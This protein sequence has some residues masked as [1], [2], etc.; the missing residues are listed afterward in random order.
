MFKRSAF[1]FLF[2]I[3]VVSSF[4]QEELV[5][6]TIG[7]KFHDKYRYSNMLAI[8]DD[9]SD[10]TVVVRAYYTGIILRPKGYF[11]EHYNKDL[12][13]VSEYNYKLKDANFIDA[14]V[15][16]GQVYL[17]FLEYSYRNKSYQYEVHRS[18]F[19]QFQFTK[20]TI[21]SI[22]SD[23]VEQPLDRNFYN[24]NFSSGFTTSIL[25]NDDKSAF[26]ITTHY[27][28]RKV[29]QHT[30]HVFNA[31]LNKLMEHDFSDEVEEKNYA[32]ENIAF[33]K[34]LQNVYLVGKAYF[35]KKRFNATE[36]KFQY[37]MV[38][39]SNSSRS[40]QSFYTPG[41]FPE[42]LKPIFRDNEL[43]CIGF[44]ADRKD[45]RYNGI[46]YFNLDPKTLEMKTEKFNPFSEQFM[47]D[48]FGRE[49]DK[50][51]KDL[52]FK[53]MDITKEGNILF[54]AEEYFTSNSVQ[55]NSSGGR[56]MVTRYHHNDIISAKL[57]ATG[58]VV[59]A[60]NINKTEVTQG[61]GAYASYSSYTKN[62][63]TYFFISTSSENPQQL[64]DD[65]I[66]FKQGLSRNRNV[67]LIR[68]DENGHMKYN[69]VIDDTEVRL[70]LMVS[71]PYI[72]HQK[73]ELRFYAKRGTKKQLVQ[74]GVK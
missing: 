26:A 19:S 48:K 30:I 42:S 47:M 36:R 34:D 46:S 29:D 63:T 21:L 10:G 14:Y 3:N 64:S 15:R 13:L 67:F 16:N 74:V 57:N 2:L 6:Y 70:P 22:A 49:D 66:M 41:K 61:D 44:Y 1:L 62:N 58:D 9:G 24:R 12:E 56:V 73:D 69:K 4:A 38:R 40:V 72:N 35:K 28:K 51:I 27:K 55:S 59:W 65:R 53:G 60:R 25:F 68:L 18:P 50:A 8:A 7:E 32:F 71:V 43:L 54:N 17:L 33:S 20:E 31:N 45:N 39:I 37:E 23:P 11:I 5:S 52:V